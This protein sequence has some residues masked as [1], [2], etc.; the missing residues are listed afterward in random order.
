MLKKSP[1]I[2]TSIQLGKGRPGDVIVKIADK[3]N[4]DVIVLG[5]RGY[6]IITGW[7]LGSTSRHVLEHCT[8]PILII[9]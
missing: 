7:I 9:K 5:S 8:K 1:E 3:E 2:K 4:V 6:G